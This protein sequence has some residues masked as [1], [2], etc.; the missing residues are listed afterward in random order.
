MIAQ[1][2]PAERRL[3]V[4]HPSI[5]FPRSVYTPSRHSGAPGLRSDSFGAKNSSLA[6][7][8]APPS[9]SDARS[10]RSVNGGIDCRSSVL[11]RGE[12]NLLAGH[13]RRNDLTQELSSIVGRRLL[14]RL[15]R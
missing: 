2:C 14:A 12:H 1:S 13:V 11:L 7:T 3:R 8:T 9:R 5:H 4:S 6:A 15:L 10:I